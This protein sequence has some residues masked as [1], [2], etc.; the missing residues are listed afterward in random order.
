MKTFIHTH[1]TIL[2]V[3]VVQ[4]Y[5]LPK[6]LCHHCCIIKMFFKPTIQPYKP[7]YK[8]NAEITTN[9]QVSEPLDQTIVV[10][11]QRKGIPP[12]RATSDL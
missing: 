9:I 6:L 3:P 8:S 7:L 2:Q 4:S 12:S 1:N 11:D 10:Q 5:C